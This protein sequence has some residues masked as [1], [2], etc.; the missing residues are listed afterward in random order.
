MQQTD[1]VDAG[2]RNR[3]VVYE[4]HMNELLQLQHTI[5]GELREALERDDQLDV[6]F[7]PL[8]KSTCS[9]VTN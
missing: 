3:A 9:L 5:E 8:D 7:Q 6:A 4:E 2:G 1:A